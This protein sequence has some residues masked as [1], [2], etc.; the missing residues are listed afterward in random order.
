MSSGRDAATPAPP[1]PLPPQPW[2][3]DDVRVLTTTELTTTGGTV[4]KAAHAALD[5]LEKAAGEAGL[6]RPGAR[7]RLCV[8]CVR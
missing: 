8:V 4:W 2:R 6:T 5:F 3:R 1:P 7:V